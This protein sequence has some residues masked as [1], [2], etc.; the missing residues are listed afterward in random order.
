MRFLR[1]GSM[2]RQEKR[3]RLIAAYRRM[4]PQ[5]RHG[6]DKT[7]RRLAALPALPER[8]ASP[9]KGTQKVRHGKIKSKLFIC[10]VLFNIISPAFTM[11]AKV[12][13][14]KFCLPGRN[15]SL[16]PPIPFSLE[17]MPDTPVT[18]EFRLFYTRFCVAET[19]A[20]L[21]WIAHTGG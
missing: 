6:L 10:M 13:G 9:E 19:Y 4:N 17:K 2:T 20:P 11:S 21:G 16:L 15:V 7:V 3:A 14:A 8:T 12:T 1:D 18:G 5:Q